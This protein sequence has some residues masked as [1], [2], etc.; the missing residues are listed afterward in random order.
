[1]PYYIL[2]CYLLLKLASHL[3]RTRTTMEIS[4]TPIAFC[5]IL[6][7]VIMCRIVH[8]LLASCDVSKQSDHC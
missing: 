3:D 1:M 5:V 2:K 6:G 8:I 4:S 7:I